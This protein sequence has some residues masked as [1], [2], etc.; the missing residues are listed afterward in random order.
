MPALPVREY[1]RTLLTGGGLLC[2]ALLA[3][4]CA[5]PVSAPGGNSDSLAATAPV[6]VE[7]SVEPTVAAP[8]PDTPTPD[9][10][11]GPPSWQRRPRRRW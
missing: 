10:T 4:G 5:S 2:L 7:A 1:A 6:A 3:V 8:P 9:A 11:R